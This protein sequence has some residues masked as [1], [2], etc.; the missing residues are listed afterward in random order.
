MGDL[1]GYRDAVWANV[2]PAVGQVPEDHLETGFNPWMVDDRDVH[3]QASRAF[4]RA[5][6]QAA[7]QLWKTRD[8]ASG[9]PIEDRETGWLQNAPGGR[10]GYRG[11]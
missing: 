11:L 5:L 1:Y 3:R 7:G 6:H 10:V 4:Q 2:T 9:G 8:A